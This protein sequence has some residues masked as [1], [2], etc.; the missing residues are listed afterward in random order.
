MRVRARTD[1][2]VVATRRLRGLAH[3]QRTSR[4]RATTGIFSRNISQMKVHAS[5]PV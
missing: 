1:P 5:T 4:N 2:A 3:R